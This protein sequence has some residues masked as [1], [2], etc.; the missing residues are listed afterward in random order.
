MTARRLMRSSRAAVAL[1]AAVALDPVFAR[2]DAQA[3]RSDSPWALD[4]RVV[5]VVSGGVW[6]S[7]AD[8]GHYRVIVM[9]DGVEQVRHSAVVQW[10]VRRG[11]SQEVALFRTV[12]LVEV[13]P[14]WFSFLDPEIRLSR[15]RWILTLVAAD[16]PLRAATHRPQ[17]ILGPPGRVTER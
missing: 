3:P 13:S 10:L 9:S 4:S 15:G 7:G 6:S 1:V 5:Q 2:A 16:R 17:F 12:N 11:T 14:R 8:S